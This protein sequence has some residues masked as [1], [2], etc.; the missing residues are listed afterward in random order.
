MKSIKLILNC[1]FL[2][3]TLH[4][5]YF[6]DNRERFI[7]EIANLIAQQQA[8][9]VPLNDIF[10]Q[11]LEIAAR[12]RHEAAIQDRDPDAGYFGQRRPHGIDMATPLGGYPLTACLSILS[13][14]D[15]LNNH[16]D[17]MPHRY[18]PRSDATYTLVHGYTQN[19]NAPKH[20]L[21]RFG[22]LG[23]NAIG[24]GFTYF[25]DRR[26]NPATVHLPGSAIFHADNIA[27]A[28]EAARNAFREL[29]EQRGNPHILLGQLHYHLAAGAPFAR[30]SAAIAE[31]VTEGAARVLR[32]TIIYPTNRQVLEHF[33]QV[34]VTAVQA[35]AIP[36]DTPIT[37]GRTIIDHMVHG[38]ITQ[39]AFI[40]EYLALTRIEN[41]DQSNLRFGMRIAAYCLL[42]I[43]AYLFCFSETP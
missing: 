29:L 7:T 4:A 26:T 22:Q 15:C 28:L 43:F 17:A 3:G 25:V 1:I 38:L 30:G 24:N 37:G 20:D 35:G 5:G 39:K 11:V 40:P 2:S 31:L 32:L 21:F 9:R 6:D 10:D 19:P 42:S 27:A 16:P 23:S 34:L 33:G 36:H 13:L 18:I 14:N 8:R 41:L 12:Q